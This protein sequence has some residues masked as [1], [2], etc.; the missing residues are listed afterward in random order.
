MWSG[1]FLGNLGAMY[2]LVPSAKLHSLSNRI[3]YSV[4]YIPILVTG[5][6]GW[7]LVRRRWRE[8]T[9]LWAWVITNTVLICIYV[10]SIRYR[11]ASV[12]PLLML[13]TGIC[14]AVLLRRYTP[15]TTG[16]K[17]NHLACQT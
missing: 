1:M 2:T 15:G 8:L 6:A 16:I 9:L 11:V 5:I 10:S 14:V 3:I 17:S 13:G 4:S 7:I 12:E